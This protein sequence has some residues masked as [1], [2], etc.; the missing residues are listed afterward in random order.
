MCGLSAAE[1]KSAHAL[2]LQWPYF[3]HFAC[4]TMTEANTAFLI[5]NNNQRSKAKA[6]T[7]LNNFCHTIDVN[8]LIDELAIAFFAI[9]TA[10]IAVPF[11][12]WCH[13]P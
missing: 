12:L 13:F 4:L 10:I 8:Q 1:Q 11:L 3:W 6:T 7:A 2:Q 9:A 5:A